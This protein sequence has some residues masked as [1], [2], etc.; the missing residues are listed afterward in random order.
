MTANPRYL[1]IQTGFLGDAILATSLL[2]LI[3]KEE[4]KATLD[5]L[6]SRRSAPAFERHPYLGKLWV[7]D[8]KKSKYGSLFALC[9][10]IRER[11]Y[12]RVYNLH[13]HASS[14][15]LTFWSGAKEKIGYDK[16]PFGFCYSRRVRHEFDGSHE[17]QRCLKLYGKDPVSFVKPRIYPSLAHREKVADLVGQG[18][19][20]SITPTSAWHTKQLPLQKWA[21]LI[22]SI[23][24]E[25]AVYLMGAPEDRGIC[26]NVKKGVARRRVFNV[27]RDLSLL[28]SAALME[29]A[30]MNYA[31]DSSATHLASAVNAP[32]ATVFCSTSPRYGF[33]PLS[34]QSYVIQTGERLNCRPCGPHGRAACPRRHFRCVV[35]IGNEN[36]IRPL[37]E[38]LRKTKTP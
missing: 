3:R 32:V 10:Q 23:P 33:S 4:Q 36:L 28:E 9:R 12:R 24:P 38:A 6:I 30:V 5:F 16:N 13:R 27:T 14:G 37:R 7:W 1:L 22:D 26:E 25:I 34:D 17:V 29:G 21:E 18:R 19:Y 2:E 11:K 20:V 35:S 31:N 8:K 15:L